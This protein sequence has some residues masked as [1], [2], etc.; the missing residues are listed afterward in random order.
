MR[1]KLRKIALAA[2]MIVAVA[3]TTVAIPVAANARWGGVGMVAVIGMVA[4]G[5]GVASV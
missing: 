4:V 3:G 2:A 1:N 5:V